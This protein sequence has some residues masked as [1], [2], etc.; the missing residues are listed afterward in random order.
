MKIKKFWVIGRKQWLAALCIL[1][2]SVLL[3]A[4]IVKIGKAD[5]TG[6]GLVNQT[7][8]KGFI[9]LDPGHGG[10]DGGAVGDDGT[11][12]KDINLAVALPLR[13]MLSLF[14][15]EVRMTRDSDISI[16]SP[17]YTTIK[18]QKISDLK[19]RLVMYEQAA[20][21][22]GIHQNKFEVPRYFGTQV[23]YSVNNPSSELLA[24]S[25]RENV[26]SL[27][28]PQNTRELKKGDKNIYL[29]HKTSVPAVL[30][31]C[32]FLS[33]PEERDKLKTE[34]YQHQMA[35]AILA[36]IMQYM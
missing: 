22:V 17:E 14:G 26:I 21:V 34:A 13:D 24:D 33:N 6:A 10:A 36:G 12:E 28:Q 30:V 2:C 3:M 25:I 11:Q 23:F 4:S 31:E 16:H 1:G 5:P 19:N 32:G 18:E 27:L 8:E 20:L 7:E 29:L 35:Y 9:L 15:Y